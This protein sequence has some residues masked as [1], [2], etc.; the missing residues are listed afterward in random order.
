VVVL[1]AAGKEEK[2]WNTKNAESARMAEKLRSANMHF[3]LCGSCPRMVPHRYTPEIELRQIVPK[4][5]DDEGDEPLPAPAAARAAPKAKKPRVEAPGV[6]SKKITTFYLS[7]SDEEKDEDEP[8]AAAP[9][10][11]PRRV[12][13][14][15][16]KALPLSSDDDGEESEE[17]APGS[18]DEAA[19]VPAVEGEDDWMLAAE[20]AAAAREAQAREPVADV[21]QGVLLFA[22][23][24]GGG[25]SPLQPLRAAQRPPR[26][27]FASG[28]PPAVTYD[29][30]GHVCIQPPRGAAGPTP[31][32]PSP[33]EE[34]IEVENSPPPPHFAA[35]AA[36]QHCSPMPPPRASQRSQ[37]AAAAP[38]PDVVI[39]L[40]DSPDVQDG[41]GDAH[42]ALSPRASAEE[43]RRALLRQ[44]MPPPPPPRRTS[45]PVDAAG[46]ASGPSSGHA[47]SA[48]LSGRTVTPVPSGAA[49]MAI[50]SDGSPAAAEP[51]D[52]SPPAAAAAFGRRITSM[53]GSGLDTGGS[54]PLRVRRVLK[55]KVLRDSMDSDDAPAAAAAGGAAASEDADPFAGAPAQPRRKRLVRKGGAA[56]QEPASAA[57]APRG[58]A[59]AASKPKA[60]RRAAA[61]YFD[62]EAGLS[63]DA[64]VS[65]DEDVEDGEEEDDSFV[66]D[67]TGEPESEG[68]RA[69]Y[70]RLMVTPDSGR[71]SGGAPRF[72][73]PPV[74]GP[75]YRL[76]NV[77]AIG[78]VADSPSPGWLGGVPRVESSDIDTPVSRDAEEE[79]EEEEE[80]AGGAAGG[81]DPNE[82]WCRVCR[83][84]GNL[85]CCDGC[86]AAY[87]PRC[88]NLPGVPSDAWFCPDCVAAQEA[89]AIDDFDF[90]DP[91]F[92]H[93]TAP[94]AAPPSAAAAP[95]SAPIEVVTID[96]GSSD[97]EPNFNL[98][99]AL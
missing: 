20:A 80:D 48:G 12:V 46:P 19:D 77:R 34:V 49:L 73:G 75:A 1:A 56:S 86:E 43:R 94:S 97:D 14:K 67:G 36:A 39:D 33:M 60:K 6:K 85:M 72:A 82:D 31:P 32:P 96:D 79:A 16:A 9:K 7:D 55:R 62:E 70:H 10:P 17:K 57:A 23:A 2:A 90:G 28:A 93:G 95:P 8:L 99:L 26:P 78:P 45:T 22:A 21:A 61:M 69:M 66:T 64:D 37:R 53:G 47:P 15:A 44:S 35:A 98:G 65:G 25:A 58:R 51:A 42:A 3:E 27:L 38:P 63:S 4:D 11:A 52:E 29:A 59:A 30:A 83:D 84:G 91:G 68:G 74:R 88:L 13:A 18:D 87:H 76:A 41:A 40:T 71:A 89:T 24:L 50:N 92:D 54:A 81:D 5:D